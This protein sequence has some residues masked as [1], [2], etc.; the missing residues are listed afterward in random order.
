M[1]EAAFFAGLHL[2][3]TPSPRLRKATASL[4][5]NASEAEQTPFA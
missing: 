4:S 2:R 5:D 1:K 3:I